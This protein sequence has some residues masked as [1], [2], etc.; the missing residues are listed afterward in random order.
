MTFFISNTKSFSSLKKLFIKTGKNFLVHF[1]VFCV[2]IIM[3]FSV[4]QAGFLL[5]KQ[6]RTFTGGG[7]GEQ[8]IIK[9]KQAEN[10]CEFSS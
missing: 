10:L 3:R 5:M 6:S 8:K 1:R 7:E 9:A 4:F 2:N